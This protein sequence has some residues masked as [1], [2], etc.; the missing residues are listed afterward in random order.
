MARSKKGNLKKVDPKSIDQRLA[1]Q[2]ARRSKSRIIMKLGS[3]LV[4]FAVLI[5]LGFVILEIINFEA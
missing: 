4:V 2:R 1:H 5:V 3:L